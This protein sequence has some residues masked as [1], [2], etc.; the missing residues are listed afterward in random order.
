M[1]IIEGLPPSPICGSP[2][3]SIEAA[4]NRYA[5]IFLLCFAVWKHKASFLET[6]DEHQ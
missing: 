6:Y 3:A 5:F 2:K 4:L 1:Y